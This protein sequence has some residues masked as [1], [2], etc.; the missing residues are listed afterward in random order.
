MMKKGGTSFAPKLKKVIRKKPGANSKAPTPATPPATQ[1]KPEQS[2]EEATS[3]TTATSPPRSRIDAKWQLESPKN[4]QVSEESNNEK[5][6][7]R[8]TLSKESPKKTND[9]IVIDPKDASAINE[10]AI[11]S[12]S[13]DEDK[14]DNAIDEEMFKPPVDP[15]KSRR[16]S[17]TQRRLSNITT[18]GMR[19]RSA[20]ISISDPNHIPA[21]IGIPIAKQVKRRRSSAQARGAKKIATGKTVPK[22]AVVT[23]T[24]DVVGKKKPG[25]P[26]SKES[27]RLPKK[28]DKKGVSDEFIVGV[29]PVTKK[30]TK[31]R[32]K[33]AVIK[34]EETD[35][36]V[37]KNE[38]G[39]VKIENGIKE[40]IIPEAP[41]DLITTITSIHQIP[42]RISDED[43]ELYG[44]VDID[45]DEMTMAELCKPTIHIGKVSSNFVL[46]QEARDELR[47]RRMQRKKDR[48]VARSERISLNDAVK[49]NEEERRQNGEI[50]YTEERPDPKKH[51]L[52]EDEPL[53][54]DNSL[55]LTCNAD[56]KID[57][58]ATS[59][60][61]AKPRAD[62]NSSRAV[63]QS[64]P[65]ANPVTSTTYSRRIHTD[66]WTSEELSSFYQALSM[67]GTDF[68]LIAQLFPY[69]TRKQIKS[70][71]NLEEKKFPEII[72]LALRRK[73]PV[74]FEEYCQST[75]ND[76]KS[77]EYYNEELRKVRIEHEQSMNNIALEREKALKEDAEA[78]RRREIEIRTGAKPM[79]RAEKMKELRK[80]ETVVGSIDDVKRQREAESNE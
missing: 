80:N 41:D 42:T 54:V 3:T 8:I 56:G 10:N 7:F 68:S 30:L 13:E 38:D 25:E 76:I 24:D 37:T 33:G 61:V 43:I 63:E 78:N 2:E 11:E 51:D 32:R 65:F 1:N 23:V 44:E 15:S 77:L 20:S 69:R 71:F 5:P 75:K 40:K 17:L 29:D 9:E 16:Q 12:S 64:N 73:L 57:F 45:L 66:K 59:T 14:D 6:S 34:K 27:K 19:S 70:K 31:F 49:R 58:D 48:E 55:Q 36:A 39:T 47:K 46:A 72:E 22:P 60:I 21:K 79:T 4:T 74:D 35:E 50:V 52:L 28:S 53:A 67:F 18:T 62:M 26:G